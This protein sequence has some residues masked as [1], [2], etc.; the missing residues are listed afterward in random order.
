MFHASQW[1][2]KESKAPVKRSKPR[3]AQDTGP[4][5]GLGQET[6]EVTLAQGPAQE[7]DR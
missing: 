4:T 6:D 2:A 3:Q 5:W 7:V 1:R